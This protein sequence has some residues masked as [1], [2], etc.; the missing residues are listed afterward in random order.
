MLFSK[1]IPDENTVKLV[2]IMQGCLMRKILSV[3]SEK[4]KL[5][6]MEVSSFTKPSNSAFNGALKELFEA[7]IVRACF[8]EKGYWNIE[9]NLRDNLD[10]SFVGKSMNNYIKL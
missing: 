10:V 1:T 3:L 5:I 8:R 4:G 7:G 2:A 6:D 9:D